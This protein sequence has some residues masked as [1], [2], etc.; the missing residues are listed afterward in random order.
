MGFAFWNLERRLEFGEN[1]VNR[2]QSTFALLSLSSIVAATTFRVSDGRE[3][4]DRV[5]E[6]MGIGVV[7]TRSLIMGAGC[8]CAVWLRALRSTTRPS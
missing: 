2:M 1:E 8:P 5:P 4:V 7:Y 6:K 3:G